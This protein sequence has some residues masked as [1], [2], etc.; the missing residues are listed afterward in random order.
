MLMSWGSIYAISWFGKTNE[1][2]GWGSAYPFDA[3]GSYLTAD[4]NLILA[5]TTQYR[6]D[7]TEY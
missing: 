1:S 7:A 6:A 5:D 4:T 3:D 2:N